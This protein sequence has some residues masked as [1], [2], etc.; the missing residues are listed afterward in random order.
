MTRDKIFE[1]VNNEYGTNPE[2]PWEGDSL[3]AVLRNNSG[4]WYGIIMRIPGSR[5]G[6]DSD[7]L[8][9]VMNVKCDPM[10]IDSL[11]SENGFA[12]AYHMNKKNWISI[13]L[14][15]VDAD[16]IKGLIDLS[17]RLTIK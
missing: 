12:P 16:E 2:Y 5:I 9:D 8:I 7:N 6:L 10:V 11:L 14:D 1:W 15:V 4:K 3:S 13:I 17:Y